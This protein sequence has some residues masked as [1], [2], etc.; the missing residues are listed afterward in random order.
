MDRNIILILCG[1]HAHESENERVDD[2]GPP[3]V[4]CGS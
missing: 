4:S 3:H 1:T 2:R